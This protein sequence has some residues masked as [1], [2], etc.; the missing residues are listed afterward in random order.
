MKTRT[1]TYHRHFIFCLVA[2]IFFGCG[3]DDKTPN[4]SQLYDNK[5]HKSR[6]INFS[7]LET[8][9]EVNTVVLDSCEYL[10]AWF[11]MGNGGGSFT[12]KGN[13]KFCAERSKK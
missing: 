8:N 10:Y 13:C 4:Q 6:R 2:V 12:H 9:I 3:I 5:A 1:S 7:D 11:G